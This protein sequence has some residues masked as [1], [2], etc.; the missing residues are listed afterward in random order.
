VGKFT[1][2]KGGGQGNCDE[3]RGG[4]RNRN[5]GQEKGREKGERK[6]GTK[7]SRLLLSEG[8]AAQP[9]GW[10]VQGWGQGMLGR[11]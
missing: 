9:L 8:R 7:M 3:K 11:N 10:K 5:K 4:R 6:K 1:D 2:P